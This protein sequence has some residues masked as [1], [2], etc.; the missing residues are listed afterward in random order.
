[1]AE[2]ESV[3]RDRLSGSDLEPSFATVAA[4]DPA[5]VVT[6]AGGRDDD[7]ARLWVDLRARDR[8][9]LY[10]V[11]GTWERVLVRH[12]PRHDNP[13]VARE[14]LGHVVE[15]ALLALR[16]GERIGIG[17]DAARAELAPGLAPEPPA[18][19]AIDA[20]PPRSPVPRAAPQAAVR[21][22]P[23]LFYEAAAYAG[24]PELSSGPGLLLELRRSTPGSR[25]AFGGLVSAQYRL[26][27]EA[28]TE[29]VT[30]TTARTV[31]RIEGGAVHLLAAGSLR[32]GRASELSL[33]VGGGIEL[34][35]AAARGDRASDIRVA[36]GELRAVPALRALAR[37]EHAVS[38]L[39]LFGGIGLDVPLESTRYLLGRPASEPVVLFEPWAARPFLLAGIQLP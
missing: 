20:P 7:L 37:Y 1:V 21:L 32:L 17:R 24:G 25:L 36:D 31:V 30:G 3:L 38:A 14:E 9:T 12:F 11:D 2:V 26:P 8:L 19:P 18:P 23:G 6:P 10:L 34:V 29:P 28:A 27:A 39:R 16:A 15:L 35:H 13:E 5:V 22:R 4:V 33:A